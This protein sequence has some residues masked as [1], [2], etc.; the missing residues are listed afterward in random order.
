MSNDHNNKFKGEGYA[1]QTRLTHM[2][3]DPEAYFGVVNPP[4][5]RTSTILYPSLAAYNDPDT[6]FRYARMGNPLSVA[7]ET[8]IAELE[9]G[10]NAVSTCSGLGA[11]SLSLLSFL[12]AG[13]HILVVDSNYPPMRSFCDQTL[14]RYGVE[15][16]YYD[17]MIGAG[18][19]DLVR[20][21]TAVIYMESPGSATF[22][23]QD[24][25]AIVAVAK[26]NDIVTVI[27]NSWASG[28]LY[29][30]LSFG[31]DVSVISCTKYIGGH[32][33][34]NLGA[35]IAADEE[36]YAKL[37]ETALNIGVCAGMEDLYGALRGMRTLGVR[38][39]QNAENAVAVMDFLQ[40]RDEVQKIYY[41]ALPDH[42]GHDVWKR[43]FMGANGVFSILLQPCSKAVLHG[44]VD[45]LKLFPVG[46][47][48]GGYESLLQ[49]QYMGGCR[50]AV[51]WSGD[52]SSEGMLLRL[53]VGLEDP[54]DL[55][56]D[57]EQAFVCFNADS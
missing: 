7:F 35:V 30:P 31:V 56:A 44:F 8:S 51:P 9:G 47:S 45:A 37:K 12:S 42:A 3:R 28:Y 54:K 36:L 10:Y 2:G 21:N 41:P 11:I 27:D 46:S 38:M 20:D 23:V 48:W 1:L 43:D 55:I 49:P 6:E 29:H 26:N 39:K 25:P 15:V 32:G 33:D 16:E 14:S 22:E 24:V 19:A 34:I 17:P 13:D 52:I 18:I 4:I 5:I 57:F 53:Q 50:T 40:T